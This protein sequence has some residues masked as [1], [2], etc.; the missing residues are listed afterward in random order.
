MPDSG[1]KS[2]AACIPRL[3]M[4][5]ASIAAAH[6]WALPS[7]RG[8]GK[9]E[10]SFCSWDEDSITMSVDAVRACVRGSKSST[11]GSLT[12]AS[13]TPV[14][15]DLQNAGL[16]AAASGLPENL[17][18]LDASGSLRAGTSALI[19]ALESTAETDAV[20]VAADARHAK[21]G[22]AQEMQYGAGGVAVSVGRKDVIARYVG[23]VSSAT[24]FIDHFRAEGQKYDYQWE[25]RW[26]RDEGYMKIV[27]DVV[28]RLLKQTGVEPSAVDYFC[29]AATLPGIA[30]AV[31]KRVGLKPESVV[32]NLAARCGDTGVAHPLL[33]LASAL[34]TAKPGQ[35]ILL[36]GFGTGCDALLFEA[37]DAI[38]SYKS[39]SSVSA[40]LARGVTDKSYTK[41]LSFSDELDLDWGMRAE[42]DAKTALTQLYRSRDQVISFTGGRCGNC[43]TIQFPRMPACVRC[44]STAPMSAVPLADQP[45]KVATFTADWLM[46]YPSPPLYV[47]L[48][49]FDNGAR[50]LME[51]V[52]VDPAKFDVGTRL[53]MVFRIKEKD[54]L[55]HYSRYFWKAAPLG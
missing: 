50:V 17:S 5:R 40:A 33:L 45:A 19:R 15:S 21:P 22:S 52:D 7:L 4:D 30:A 25:E 43:D 44:G 47:G 20:I 2:Y 53:R 13:T 37:T 8:L 49:Q 11:V 36:A 38:G 35:R 24:Q 42:T 34:E 48:V 46:F 14:F 6:A 9:G 41:L 27:P 32:D 55:R 54:S 29:L 16:I 10:R 23:S 51:M 18:T 26:I 1:I 12:F 3:R 39:H 31:A 28:G